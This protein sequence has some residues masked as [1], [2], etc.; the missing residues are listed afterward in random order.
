MRPCWPR[1]MH[2]KQTGHLMNFVCFKRDG[3]AKSA[4]RLRVQWMPSTVLHNM[5]V[6]VP[7]S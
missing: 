2:F 4:E 1:V 5:Q 3:F 6:K 7:P